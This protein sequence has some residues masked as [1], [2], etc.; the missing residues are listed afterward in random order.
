MPNS[1]LLKK[2]LLSFFLVISL[3]SLV[4]TASAQRRPSARPKPQPSPQASPQ[5]AKIR[6]RWSGRPN[7]S[8]YRVQ[9]ARDERFADIAVDSVVVGLET[10]V[11]DLAPGRYFWRVA[12]A[13]QETG[14]FSEAKPIQVEANVVN[15]STI[16]MAEPV[17]TTRVANTTGWRTT[18]GYVQKPLA[19]HL[20]SAT[21]FDLV[22]VSA[23]G[24]VYALDGASGMAL[25]TAR[26]RPNARR[27]EATGNGGAQAFTP[28]IFNA[29]QGLA[30]VLVAFDAGV[31]ALEGA[32]GRELWRVQLDEEATSGVAADYNQQTTSRLVV[33]YGGGK[34]L[35]I[36]NPEN[37]QVIN[38]TKIGS[39]VVGSPV[40]FVHDNT[41]EMALTLKDGTLQV[42]AEDGT[43]NVE[44]K[45]NTKFTTAPV[46]VKGPYVE[47]ILV[48]MER[49]LIAFE[50]SDLHPMGKIDFSRDGPRGT[51]N[52]S[53][54][55]GDGAPEVIAVTDTGRV[56]TISTITGQVA[57]VAD[58]ATDADSAAFADLDGDGVQDVIVAAGTKF[59]Q[60]LS[61]RDGRLLWTA[62]EENARGAQAQQMARSLVIAKAG[63]SSFLVGSDSTNTGLRAIELPRLGQRAASQ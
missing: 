59:A 58:G 50:A 12:P 27:G 55:D 13:A 47:M 5:A 11:A 46:Y 9:V 52:V 35:L 22:G 17:V 33:I 6:L 10:I 62:E 42:R 53:D 29:S 15:E 51:L 45:I 49:G 32:T 28:V 61:G 14:T 20:R 39:P 37:G 36:I 34:T 24:M 41:R 40:P 8:R 2:V 23:D 57:W 19:A 1:R 26:F 31:R 43:L 16:T 21:N 18:T 48:G 25:W 56:A 54:L 60:G 44:T 38:K 63:N 30:N 4:S 3:L 7:I